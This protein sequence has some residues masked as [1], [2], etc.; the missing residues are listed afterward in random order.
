MK[1]YHFIKFIWSISICLQLSAVLPAASVE[2]NDLKIGPW[3][4]TALKDTIPKMRWVDQASP[5]H[6]LFFAGE[7][8]K[9]RATEVFAFYASPSTIGVSD[10]P[11]GKFPGIILVHGGG[12]TAFAEWVWL[13]AQRGYAAIAMDLSGSRPKAPLYDPKT[14]SPIRNTGSSVRKTNEHLPNGG[15]NQVHADKFDSIGGDVSD[16]WPFHAVASVMRA[17]SLARPATIPR[18]RAA[19]TERKAISYHL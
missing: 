14:G 2:S 9:G 16:D 8:Y 11:Q 5:V 12:G 6:S 19:E 18:A 4:I 13:W 3:N 17:H 10:C 1:K 15:P 7:D